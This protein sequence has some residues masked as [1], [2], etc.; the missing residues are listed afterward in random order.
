MSA[1]VLLRLALV[2]ALT[3]AVVPAAALSPDEACRIIARD[4]GHY[5]ATGH[6]CPCPYS[7][8]RNGGACGNRAAWA[9]PN[10][11]APRCYVEDVDGRFP[12]NRS[13]NLTRQ[14]WP[15]PPACAVTS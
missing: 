15:P 10:G 7:A 11:K 1:P 5:L 8:M 12:P 14:S 13:P 4:I 2:L 3:T 9:K 6:P